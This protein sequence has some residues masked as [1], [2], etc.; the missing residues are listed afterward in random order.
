MAYTS[1]GQN[2]DSRSL[3]EARAAGLNAVN[4]TLGHVAG[5]AEPFLG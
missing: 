2:V 5:S 3:T 4:I 1:T